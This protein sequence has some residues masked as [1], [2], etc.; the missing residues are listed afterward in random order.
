[1]AVA[2]LSSRRRILG[3]NMVVHPEGG[4]CRRIQ[5]LFGI[6]TR[7]HN[8]LDPSGILSDMG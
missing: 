2:F 6:E 5:Q 1:M 4:P 7:A 8:A 3:V